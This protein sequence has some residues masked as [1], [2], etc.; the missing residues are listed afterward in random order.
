MRLTTDTPKNNLEMA[1]NL[2]YAKDKEVWVRGYGKNGADISLF[3]LSRDL[4]RWNC[5]YVDLDISDD[6]FSM[7]MAEWLWEDVESFEHVLALLYQTAWVCAELREH[8]K[9]FEDSGCE[10]EEVLQKGKADEIALKLM[11]LADLVSLCCYD[12][13]RELAEADKEGRVLILPCKV[14]DTVYFVNAKQILEFAVVGYAVDETG[15]SWVHSEHVDKIGNTNER[16]FSPDRFGKN[17]FFTREE[18][19]KALEARK[20]G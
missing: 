2:F 16:T 15:I 17:T 4:T 13:L 8:L 12:H 18:A 6:S 11:R 9:Q 3:D 5:P 1:L 7:M 10:P 14:G 19:E 20:D